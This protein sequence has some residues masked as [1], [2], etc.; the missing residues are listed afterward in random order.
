MDRRRFVALA[1]AAALVAPLTGWT[2]MPAAASGRT[3]STLAAVPAST[4]FPAMDNGDPVL[5]TFGFSPVA[6]DSRLGSKIVSFVAT[7]EDTGGPGAASG[8]A[9]ATVFVSFDDSGNWNLSAPMKPDGNGGLAGT[10]SILSQY[11]TATR[12]VSVSVFDVAGNSTMYTTGDLQQMGLPTTF[13][14]VT[15]P[16]VAPPAVRTVQLSTRTI[17]TREHRSSLRVRVR[18]TDDS[19][20]KAIRVWLWGSPIRSSTA[21]LRLVAGTAADG[22]WQGM[23]RVPRWQGNSTAKLAIEVTDLLDGSRTYGPKKL[24]AIGQPGTVRVLSRSDLQPPAL[25][26][27]SVTPSTVDLRTGVQTVTVSVRVTDRLSGARHVALT[28]R[29]PETSDGQPSID[30]RLVRVAGTAR[31]GIWQ[32]TVGLRPCDVVAGAWDATVFAWDAATGNYVDSPTVLTVLNADVRRPTAMLVGDYYQARRGGPLTVEFGEDVV[33]VDADNALVHVGDNQRGQA[34]D[35]PASIAGTWACKNA[36]GTAVDCST[37]PVRTAAFTPTSPMLAATNHTLV[38]NPEHHL[39]LTDLA[40]N[41]Y[42]PG[43]ALGFHTI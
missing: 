27:R 7:A 18:A 23:V 8:V 17:D 14:T 10:L 32:G 21:H 9:G 36:A 42:N 40:G 39:G 37:G 19:A 43:S 31:D 15:T 5:K 6:I 41:P 24:A 25:R 4:C 34:G 22:T 3:S 20:V 28:L 26:L 2:A 12:Y 33:G 30:A 29:G 38:L 13:T 1:G 16:D 35:N 11:R